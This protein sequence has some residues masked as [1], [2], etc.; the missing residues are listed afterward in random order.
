MADEFSDAASAA[1][2]KLAALKR[3]YQQES[4]PVPELAEA[5]HIDASDVA[6][7]DDIPV[8]TQAVLILDESPE[9]IDIAGPVVDSPVSLEEAAA[10][11]TAEDLLLEKIIARLRPEMERVIQQTV[12]A[13]LEGRNDR[14]YAAW[15]AGLRQR[16]KQQLDGEEEGGVSP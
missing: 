2:D 9:V 12:Q 4:D 11:L 5:V 16:S 8:L 14:I 3:R 7:N 13:A 1:F 6:D 10:P 15:L